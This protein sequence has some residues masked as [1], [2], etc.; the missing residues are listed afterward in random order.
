[1]SLISF[2][3]SVLT[4]VPGPQDSIQM[5]GVEVLRWTASPPQAGKGVLGIGMISYNGKLV[6]TVTGKDTPSI[7]TRTLLTQLHP[8]D[9]LPGKHE[10]IARKLT[11]SFHATFNDFV[12]EAR[13]LK[14]D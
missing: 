11:Q 14:K 8:A 3:F 2:F 9:K 7:D 10:G 4:N 5:D 6:W 1:M 13:E 12:A